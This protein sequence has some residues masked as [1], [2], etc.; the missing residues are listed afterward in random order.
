MALEWHWMEQTWA[1]A[2]PVTPQACD[3]L[4][5]LLNDGDDGVYL[6]G[7]CEESNEVMHVHEW[8]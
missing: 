7:F 4:H 8:C 3:Y 1:K 5:G 6:L 2:R